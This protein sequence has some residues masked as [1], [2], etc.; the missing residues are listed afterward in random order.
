MSA[1]VFD[2]LKASH[3]L[4]AAGISKPHAEAIVYSMADAFSDTVATKADLAEL[5]ATMYKLA[6][7]TIVAVPA[8]TVTLLRLLAESSLN[9]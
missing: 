9:P 7:G 6:A 2:T 5:K 4:Q 1:A 8:L 3:K